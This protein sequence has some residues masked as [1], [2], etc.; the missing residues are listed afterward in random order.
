MRN[1]LGA[2]WAAEWAEGGAFARTDNRVQRVGAKR[3]SL[4]GGNQP[5]FFLGSAPMGEIDDPRLEVA[6]TTRLW[7]FFSA[8][9]D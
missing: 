2:V 4:T 6:Q 7:Q 8:S 5:L 3:K 1:R 9:P